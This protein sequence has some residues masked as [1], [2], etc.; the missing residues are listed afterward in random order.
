MDLQSTVNYT[1][2]S[3]L[4][5]VSQL[6]AQNRLSLSQ[7]FSLQ[8]NSLTL[9]IPKASMIE[10]TRYTINIFL[11]TFYNTTNIVSFDVRSGSTK[12]PVTDIRGLETLRVKRFSELK[13]NGSFSIVDCNPNAPLIQ[14]RIIVE[15]FKRN[16]SEG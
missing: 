16:K 14:D 9:T 12:G 2:P 1:D 7:I 3:Q 10:R 8:N 15:W 11:R 13:L 4:D 6:Q 5:Q